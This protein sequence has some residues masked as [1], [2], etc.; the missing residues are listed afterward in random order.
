MSCGNIS[1][2]DRTLLV[3]SVFWFVS[4]RAVGSY[5]NRRISGRGDSNNEK[6]GVKKGNNC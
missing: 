4:L 2:S 6:Y 1:K 5:V 3:Q